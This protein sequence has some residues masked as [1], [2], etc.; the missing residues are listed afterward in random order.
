LALIKY[1]QA[2]LNLSQTKLTAPFSG[3]V[4]NWKV[5]D[6]D[7]L[8]SGEEIGLLHDNSTFVVKVEVPETDLPY[9]K[10]GLPATIRLLAYPDTT[11]Q[12]SI[13][14]ITPYVN[15]KG[16]VPVSIKLPR[17]TFLMPGMKVRADL[18][19]P[20]GEQLLVPKEAIVI[21]SGREVVFTVEDGL[22]KW[23]YVQTGREN[24][25][26]VEV[27]EGIENGM[28]AIVSNNIQLAH[29]APVVV[30]NNPSNN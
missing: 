1:E 21:R 28:M 30:D 14:A 7:R 10:A 16:M 25:K 22:A 20:M 24:G 5:N 12:G 23:N 9:V 2:R 3:V 8:N 11:F 27:L 17:N 13:A 29:D 19:S 4:T 18:L 15:E 6:G 26:Q